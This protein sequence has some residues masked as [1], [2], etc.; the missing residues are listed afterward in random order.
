LYAISP[1]VLAAGGAWA[2]IGGIN[3]AADADVLAHGAQVTATVTDQRVSCESPNATC[4]MAVDYAFT[5]PD[6]LRHKGSDKNP[7]AVGSTATVWYDPQHPD[8]LS[9]IHEPDNGNG[10]GMIVLGSVFLLLGLGLSAWL[11]RGALR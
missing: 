6:G 1:L 4:A 8:D 9:T 3:D 11:I 5:T 10:V 7:E 2:L